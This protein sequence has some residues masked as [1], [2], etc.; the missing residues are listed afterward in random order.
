MPNTSV[1]LDL[2][3]INQKYSLQIL[4]KGNR[5][6]SILILVPRD[7]TVDILLHFPQSFVC[8]HHTHTLTQQNWDHIVFSPSIHL[9]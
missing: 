4:Y 2:L 5:R 3:H 8:L 1:K 7:S 9:T 6:Q